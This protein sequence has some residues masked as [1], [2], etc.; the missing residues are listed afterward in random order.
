VIIDWV[1]AAVGDP[2]ADV[3]R[4]VVLI[5]GGPL[6]DRWMDRVRIRRRRAAF[7]RGYLRTYFRCSA[8]PRSELDGWLPLVAAARLSEVDGTHAE[9]LLGY[10]AGA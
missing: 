8:R 9:A 4:T 2:L 10:L 5:E 1:D 7:L 3:A 6:P